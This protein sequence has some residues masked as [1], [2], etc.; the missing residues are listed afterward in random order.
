MAIFKVEVLDAKGRPVPRADDLVLFEISGSA[1][2]I[3]V[4]NGNPTRHEPDVASRRK[5]FNG[6]CQAIVWTRR[7]GVGEVRATASA[8]GLKASSV[9]LKL[10]A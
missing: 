5:A 3:G 7:G 4:G 9:V 10:E 8:K 2:V 6:P 1:E